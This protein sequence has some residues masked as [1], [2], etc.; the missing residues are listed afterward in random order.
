MGRRARNEESGPASAGLIEGG[1]L[2]CHV[3]ALRIPGQDIATEPRDQKKISGR[4]VDIIED[5]MRFLHIHLPY[6]HIIHGI[7][8][9][10]ETEIPVVALR[11]I[12]VNAVAHRDYTISGPIRVI[13]F[14]DRVEIRTPGILPNTVTVDSLKTGMHVLRNPTMYNILLKWQL[15]TDAGSGIPR[16]VR[17]MVE[18]TGREP[19]FAVENQE[20]VAR[21]PRPVDV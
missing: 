21:L 16:T 19:E 9:E 8:P 3:S 1:Q 5:T 15:I 20:F 14:D 18:K 10:A 12:L 6:P 11:E 4:I 2:S 7:E 17:V 13:A